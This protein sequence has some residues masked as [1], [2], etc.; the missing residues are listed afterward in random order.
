M[1]HVDSVRVFLLILKHVVVLSYVVL[2]FLSVHCIQMCISAGATLHSA[3]TW[4]LYSFKKTKSLECNDP[5][6]RASLS[7]TQSGCIVRQQ[8]K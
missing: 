2:L 7:L 8:P 3:I 6:S 4:P 5:T 1:E